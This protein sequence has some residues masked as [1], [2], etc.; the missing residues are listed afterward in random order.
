MNKR[1]LLK[2]LEPFGDDQDVP[3]VLHRSDGSSL[4]T[5]FI[6]EVAAFPPWYGAK[7]D[8]SNWLVGIHV[9]AGNGEIRPGLFDAR[10]AD[11][12]ADKECQS[13]TVIPKP[14]KAEVFLGVLD[15][16]KV[17]STAMSAEAMLAAFEEHLSAKRAVDALLAKSGCSPTPRERVSAGDAVQPCIVLDDRFW[18]DERTSFKNQVLVVLSDVPTADAA[19]LQKLLV[20]YRNDA[21]KVTLAHVPLSAVDKVRH[22]AASEAMFAEFKKSLLCGMSPVNL[23]EAAGPVTDVTWTPPISEKA[24]DCGADKCGTTHAEYCSTKT[25]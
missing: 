11:I 16:V 12:A 3:I 13:P 24:C 8:K 1:W 25:G 10:E 5:L 19:G 20:C 23:A 6:Q 9:H 15:G 7:D 14:I 18:V 2:Q 21:G 17:R 22:T 4:T